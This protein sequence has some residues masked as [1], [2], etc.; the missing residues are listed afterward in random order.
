MPVQDGETEMEFSLEFRY[1]AEETIERYEEE[2][3]EGKQQIIE[4]MKEE[5]G[6][7]K[8]LLIILVNT[9]T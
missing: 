6:F 2:D 4:G 7:L 8:E 1:F 9:R 5:I 3:E